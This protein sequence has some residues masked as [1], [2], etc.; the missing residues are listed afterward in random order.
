MAQAQTSKKEKEGKTR[1]KT[2][3]KI[4]QGVSFMFCP[5]QFDITFSRSI[6]KIGPEIRASGQ[7][8]Q[9]KEQ[10]KTP[11]IITA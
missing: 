9:D 8:K 2:N 11:C 1:R 3:F 7:I 4:I 10:K 5:I 6:N